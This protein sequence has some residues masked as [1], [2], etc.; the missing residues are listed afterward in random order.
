MEIGDFNP[1]SF[2]SFYLRP[3]EARIYSF[4]DFQGRANYLK[5][6]GK[7][8]SKSLRTFYFMLNKRNQNIFR[9]NLIRECYIHLC[10]RNQTNLIF[11]SL[12]YVS[13]N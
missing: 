11:C 4:S 10:E 8:Y 7:L 2:F 6:L 9:K 12:W 5:C 1:S 3:V 13:Y